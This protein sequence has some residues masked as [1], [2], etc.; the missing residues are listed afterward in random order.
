MENYYD[1]LEIKENASNEVIKA[2]YKTLA[3]KYHP[4]NWKGKEEFANQRFLEIRKAYEVLSDETLKRQ[5][6]EQLKQ[7]KDS[8]TEYSGVNHDAYS[9]S[10]TS[11]ENEVTEPQKQGGGIKNILKSIGKSILRSWEK[12]Q[13]E[14]NEAYLEGLELSDFSLVYF[15]RKATGFKKAGYTKAMEEKGFFERNAEG[16]LVATN[17]LKEY[18]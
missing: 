12:S 13:Q 8:S 10:T 6:D 11:N 7:M 5:Y 9:E 17:K 14:F 15:Y 16:R 2:A 18:L 4:D 3:K 1:I